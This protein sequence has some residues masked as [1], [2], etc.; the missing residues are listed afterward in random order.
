MEK[1]LKKY[2][3]HIFRDFF[4]NQKIS[5]KSQYKIF[6]KN[7]KVVKNREKVNRKSRKKISILF[8]DFFRF[9]NFLFFIRKKY[10]KIENLVRNPKIILRKLYEHSKIV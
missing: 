1:I 10:T 9:R 8:Q 5:L 6:V 3:K 2:R 7:R 4:G